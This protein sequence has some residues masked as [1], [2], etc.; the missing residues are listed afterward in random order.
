MAEQDRGKV[1]LSAQSDDDFVVAYLQKHG[2]RHLRYDIPDDGAFRSWLTFLASHGGPSDLALL[3]FVAS[4]TPSWSDETLVEARELASSVSTRRV[5]L[6]WDDPEVHR[7]PMSENLIALGCE[8]ETYQTP[9]ELE[10]LLAR[11]TADY[12]DPSAGKSGASPPAPPSTTEVGVAAI[13]VAD[14]AAEQD[15]LGFKPYVDAVAAFLTHPQT[16]EPLTMSIEG[17]WGSG[18]SSFMRLLEIVLMK[19][20]YRSIRFNAWRHEKAEELWAAFALHF[21]ESIKPKSRLARWRADLALASKQFDLSRGWADLVRVAAWFT[22]LAVA[23]I[24]VFFV[25]GTLSPTQIVS[26]FDP[27]NALHESLRRWMGPALGVS[28]AFV[29]FGGLLTLWRQFFQH[30]K[31][32]LEIDL[33]KYL[34][35]PDY[36]GKLA[37]I[38]RFQKDLEEAMS[39]YIADRKK[40]FV[41][42]DDLDRAELPQA[43]ELMRAINL[44]LAEKGPVVFIIGMDREKVAAAFAVKH[45]KLLSYLVT[46]A[47]RKMGEAEVSDSLQ[48]IFFGYGFIEKF[49]QIPFGIPEPTASNLDQ[50]LRS[51]R[52]KKAAVAKQQKSAG[53]GGARASTTSS[54]SAGPAPDATPPAVVHEYIRRLDEESDHVADLVKLIA[55]ALGNN[56]RRIKQFVNVFRLRMLIAEATGLFDAPAG[57]PAANRITLG[58]L[59]KFV[60]LELRWPL[61]LAHLDAEPRLLLTLEQIANGLPADQKDRTF[62]VAYWL[63]K[64]ELMMLLRAGLTANAP[65]GEYGLGDID[66]AKVTRVSVKV[67]RQDVV[68][69]DGDVPKDIAAAIL[70]VDQLESMG[71]HD[72]AVALLRKLE[73]RANENPIILQRLGY[74][75]LWSDPREAISYSARYYEQTPGDPSAAFNLACGYAQL[76]EADRS[77]IYLGHAIAANSRYRERARGLQ[78][79][80]FR[81]IA[82]DERFQRLT[83]PSPWT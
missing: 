81:L 24:T 48:G 73:P 78:S 22:A 57:T 72:D 59:A 23:T 32:P 35:R 77:I 28:G 43:A 49:I 6:L 58:K 75:L 36:D 60:A 7:S 61:L 14:A 50:F 4:S 1:I 2:V 20:G 71:R 51:L 33:R 80:D 5:A 13:G 45:E 30:V 65:E 21:I 55:P 44:M 31:S 46:E 26:M 56:P 27:K 19:S 74:H 9:G 83:Q 62:R 79:E 67:P 8:V 38:E 70:E 29:A 47:P 16:P 10:R 18:K 53:T 11:Y 66:I 39:V 34:R 40:V 37:F 12:V 69:P 64:P 68:P 42:I 82:D 54:S 25:A 76:G 17:P 41:F 3:V 63:G 15:E 52:P